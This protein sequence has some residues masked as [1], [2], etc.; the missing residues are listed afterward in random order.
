M[1]LCIRT[2]L[3]SCLTRT[4]PPLSRPNPYGYDA[5]RYRNPT[6]STASAIWTERK[7]GLHLNCVSPEG[8]P[9]LHLR[10]YYLPEVIHS[11]YLVHAVTALHNSW[12]KDDP[13]L[14]GISAQLPGK[15]CVSLERQQLVW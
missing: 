12:C 7:L 5:C 11:A 3:F 9:V 4:G 1:P 8:H 15:I 13:S 14:N 10:H 6:R 2:M